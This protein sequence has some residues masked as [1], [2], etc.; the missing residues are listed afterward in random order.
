MVCGAF[1]H[2]GV[3]VIDGDAGLTRGDADGVTDPGVDRMPLVQPVARGVCDEGGRAL[4]TSGMYEELTT[5][6][7]RLTFKDYIF[8][9]IISSLTWFLDNHTHFDVSPL[10]H[11]H[12]PTRLVAAIGIPIGEVDP[13]LG[14][15]GAGGAGE[16]AVQVPETDAGLPAPLLRLGVVHPGGVGSVHEVE[17]EAGR[18]RRRSIVEPSSLHNFLNMF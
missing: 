3:P 17:A 1:G 8:V 12:V 7:Q 16:G 2:R 6:F 11:L 4:V 5:V 13:P 9:L 14:D 15:H 10:A 18:R